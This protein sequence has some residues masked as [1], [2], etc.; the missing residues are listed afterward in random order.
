MFA[1]EEHRYKDRQYGDISGTSGVV[2][3]LREGEA[4]VELDSVIRPNLDGQ[5]RWIERRYLRPL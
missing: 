1:V 4:L 2:V 3:E 5:R